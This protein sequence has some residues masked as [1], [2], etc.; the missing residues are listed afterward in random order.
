MEI[1]WKTIIHYRESLTTIK[2]LTEMFW[3]ICY[4][5]LKSKKKN[6]SEGKRGSSKIERGGVERGG[7]GGEV[8]KS[9]IVVVRSKLINPFTIII[10]TY[11]YYYYLYPRGSCI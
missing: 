9:K 4:G 11:Y 5:A 8:N 7:K 2:Q 10:I 3:C 1:K 6:V